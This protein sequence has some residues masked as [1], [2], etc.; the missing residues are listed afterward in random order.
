MA[1]FHHEA[2]MAELLPRHKQILESKIKAIG[3]PIDEAILLLY[4]DRPQ[5]ASDKFKTVTELE[6]STLNNFLR[7]RIF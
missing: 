7:M 2:Q 4:L 3:S 5:E 6:E 1:P